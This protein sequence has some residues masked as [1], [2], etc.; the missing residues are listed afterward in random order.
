MH[1]DRHGGRFAAKHHAGRFAAIKHD[2]PMSSRTTIPGLSLLLPCSDRVYEMDRTEA[3]R[4]CQM[5]NRVG[6]WFG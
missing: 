1:H 6:I 2:V 4:Y 3:I 5:S